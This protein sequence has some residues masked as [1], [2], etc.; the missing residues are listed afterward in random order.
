MIWVVL[1]VKPLVQ[2]PLLVPK[3]L[4]GI[5]RL[6]KTSESHQ[7]LTLRFIAGSQFLQVSSLSVPVSG[8]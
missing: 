6:F 1:V 8:T 7:M 4:H 3:Q 2:K 5:G